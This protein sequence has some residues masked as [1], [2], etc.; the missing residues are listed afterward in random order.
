MKNVIMD[1]KTLRKVTNALLSLSSS[2]YL[3]VRPPFG[4][5]VDVM[6]RNGG[7]PKW[8][9]KNSE[10]YASNLDAYFI[11]DNGKYS[12]IVS[13]HY[14]KL[15]SNLDNI[16]VVFAVMPVQTILPLFRGVGEVFLASSPEG[17]RRLFF[18]VNVINIW[19]THPY[20]ELLKFD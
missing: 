2:T 7:R 16:T 13:P 10:P 11:F 8:V 14:D 15:S 17:V 1:R 20:K 9:I 19:I 4:P 18:P 3:S 6:G 12:T 5:Q